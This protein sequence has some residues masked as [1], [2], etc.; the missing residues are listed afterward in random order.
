[1]GKLFSNY[2]SANSKETTQFINPQRPPRKNLYLYFFGSP[3]NSP[4]LS[5]RGQ[6]CGGQG[7]GGGSRIDRGLGLVDANYYI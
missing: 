4:S 6:T 2:L 3:H 7:G 1:M 5:W